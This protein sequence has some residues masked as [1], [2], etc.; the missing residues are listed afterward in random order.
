MCRFLF[1]VTLRTVGDA[2]PYIV[3]FRLI[4]PPSWREVAFSQKMT[5]GEKSPPCIKEG[6][7]RKA[8]GR[9]RL[10]P[11]GKAPPQAVMRWGVFIEILFTIP[12]SF[13]TQNPAPFTQ[14][15]LVFATFILLCHFVIVMTF[16][17]RRR[18]RPL[19]CRLYSQ[20]FNYCVIFAR[21]R[22]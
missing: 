17:G 3:S 7:S 15:S 13:A 6:G 10:L 19:Q 8:D 1:F 5:E 22:G 18:R 14:G 11:H 16:A 20:P 21:S 4:M 12:Q 2:G 9:I